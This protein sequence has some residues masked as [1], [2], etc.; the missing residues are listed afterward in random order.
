[1]GCNRLMGHYELKGDALS[2]DQIVAERRNCPQRMGLE[3][4]FVEALGQVKGWKIDGHRLDLL[5]AAGRP[6]ACLEARHMK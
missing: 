3:K 4:A 5:D 2:F 6:V 1:M